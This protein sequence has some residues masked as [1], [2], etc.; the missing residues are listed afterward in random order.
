M[1]WARD[2]IGGVA[3]KAGFAFA[4]GGAV[5]GAIVTALVAAAIS[6]G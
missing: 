5:F 2:T 3:L 4:L 1:P 6:I